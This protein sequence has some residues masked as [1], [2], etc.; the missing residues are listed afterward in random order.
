MSTPKRRRSMT[1]T[2]EAGK[3]YT[4]SWLTN[5]RG[6]SLGSIPRA[7]RLVDAHCPQGHLTAILMPNGGGPPLV[8]VHG[9]SVGYPVPMLALTDDGLVAVMVHDEERQ[10]G[11]LGTPRAS[12]PIDCVDCD[13]AYP[14]SAS[15]LA[16]F[17]GQPGR[18]TPRITIGEP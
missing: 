13:R 3:E 9:P 4:D 5:V 18:R 2:D 11:T 17:A 1:Y 10:V 12:F 15:V 6:V 14:L 7:L 16:R 8:M